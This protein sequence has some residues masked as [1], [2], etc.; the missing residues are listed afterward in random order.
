VEIKPFL[1][2]TVA[3]PLEGTSGFAN[4]RKLD[5]FQSSV[6]AP[7][8]ESDIH[9]FRNSLSNENAND[10]SEYRQMNHVTSPVY[11]HDES[12]LLKSPSERSE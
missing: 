2:P 1:P 5:M 3:D 11:D 10:I 9:L 4:I 6:N 12:G 7:P 8:P